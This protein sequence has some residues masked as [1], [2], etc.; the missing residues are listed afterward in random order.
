MA[1][2]EVKITY[3]AFA[4]YFYWM[5]LSCP[6]FRSNE[7]KEALWVLKAPEPYDL[8]Q[9]TLFIDEGTW[10]EAVAAPCMGCRVWGRASPRLSLPQPKCSGHHG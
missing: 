1:A 7:E 2:R 4:L 8:V 6:S 3:V 5:V 10:Q 9:T